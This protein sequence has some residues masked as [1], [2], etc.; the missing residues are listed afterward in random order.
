MDG[1][2]SRICLATKC[3]FKSCRMSMYESE[4]SKVKFDTRVVVV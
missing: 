3:F 1:W 4:G 2:S